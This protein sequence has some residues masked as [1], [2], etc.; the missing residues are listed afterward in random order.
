MGDGW[1]VR[2]MEDEMKWNGSLTKLC[3]RVGGLSINGVLDGLVIGLNGDFA[4]AGAALVVVVLDLA[5][6]DVLSAH[7]DGVG[8]RWVRFGGLFDF[9]LLDGRELG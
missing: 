5:G 7:V 6:G 2:R 8:G 3:V 1:R 9:G 4:L